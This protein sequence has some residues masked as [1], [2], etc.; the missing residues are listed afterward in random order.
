MTVEALGQLTEVIV[1]RFILSPTLT[2]AL[3]RKRETQSVTRDGDDTL[4]KYVPGLEGHSRYPWVKNG[5]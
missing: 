2:M 3:T 5:R 1:R 4:T